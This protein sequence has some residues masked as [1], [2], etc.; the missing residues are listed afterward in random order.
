[1]EEKRKAKWPE[2]IRRKWAEARMEDK[3]P[4]WSQVDISAI[5][6]NIGQLKTLIPSSTKVM[7]VVKADAYGHGAVRTAEEIEDFVECFGVGR[8]YEAIELR[9][10]GVS[11]PILIF[12]YTSP[13]FTDVLIGYDLTQTVYDYKMAKEFSEAAVKQNKKLKVHI[14]L[15][16]GM[17]RLGIFLH[18]ITE[19]D[20]FKEY[21][22]KAVSEAERIAS[23]PGL[24]V[25]GIYT[26][27]AIADSLDFDYAGKQLVIFSDFL[28]ELEKKSVVFP[29]KHCAGTSA[30]L[31]FPDSCMNMVRPGK[32]IY[33]ILPECCQK[34]KISLK[35]ALSV[36]SS[37]VY[38]K[39]VPKGTRISYS[40]SYFT[41]KDTVIATI[42]IGFADGFIWESI[43]TGCVL[44]KGQRAPIIGRACMDFIMVEAEHIEGIRVGDEVVIVGEQGNEF[45]SLNEMASK[46]IPTNI[47]TFLTARTRKIYC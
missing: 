19:S 41:G 42:P 25:E 37:V 13:R 1:M 9:E 7:A 39:N 34:A 47:S 31:S 24:D 10:N 15:D 28:L 43:P 38:L 44:V 30:L 27:F 16:T 17:G 46:T 26:H 3:Y 20:S 45:V 23:L 32:L 5:K 35:Q 12:G 2:M 21:F 22:L 33:G 11:S 6:F 4:V 18:N 14:K 36:K 40:S 8:T 29:V